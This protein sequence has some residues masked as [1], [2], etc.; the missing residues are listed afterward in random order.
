[1]S[2]PKIFL[3][4]DLGPI[5]LH[6]DRVFGN[7]KILHLISSPFSLKGGLMDSPVI[8]FSFFLRSHLFI[9]G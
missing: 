9:G 8:V 5:A 6:A 1:M 3:K 4:I 7:N 2:F